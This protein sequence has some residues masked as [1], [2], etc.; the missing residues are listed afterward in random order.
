MMHQIITDPEQVATVINSV[1]IEGDIYQ[2]IPFRRYDTDLFL[3]LW[4]DHY[5]TS[6]IAYGDRGKPRFGANGYQPLTGPSTPPSPP[7]TGSNM[8]KGK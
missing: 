2:I 5:S 7:K 3:I 1:G 4:K 8:V 6:S